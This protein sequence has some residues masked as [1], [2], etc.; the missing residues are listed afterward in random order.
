MMK[1][2]VN[3]THTLT[4]IETFRSYKIYFGQN[5]SACVDEWQA[6]PQTIWYTL[7]EYTA[8]ILENNLERFLC[9]FHLL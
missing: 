1:E 2:N 5:Q 6:D 4:I 7:V 3:M 9:M 8:I